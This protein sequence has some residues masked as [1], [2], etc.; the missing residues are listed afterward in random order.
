MNQKQL[1]DAIKDAVI[2]Y[3]EAG[4]SK[5]VIDAVLKAQAEV[6]QSALQSCEEV[7]LPGIGT[8]GLKYREA[9]TGRNPKTGEALQIAAKNVPDFRFCKALK[10]AAN[11]N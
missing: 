3:H 9:R 1:I 8:V 4:V 6:A 11:S 7:T 10:D 2:S 5:V